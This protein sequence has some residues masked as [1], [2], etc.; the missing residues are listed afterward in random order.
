MLSTGF[1]QH[2]KYT[3]RFI[4]RYFVFFLSIQL[5]FVCIE[6]RGVCNIFFSRGILIKITKSAIMLNHFAVAHRYWDAQF[7]WNQTTKT[8]QSNE[9]E[10]VQMKE[11]EMMRIVMPLL[12]SRMLTMWKKAPSPSPPLKSAS[13]HQNTL[14]KGK[15]QI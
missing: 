2:I 15:F 7:N 13:F 11:T 4:C 3:C 1:Q 9:I 8:H 12:L 10:F 5:F 6:I 14:N